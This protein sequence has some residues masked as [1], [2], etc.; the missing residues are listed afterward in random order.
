MCRC[1]RVRK[2]SKEE[3]MKMFH[4]SSSRSHTSTLKHGLFDLVTVPL[5]PPHTSLSSLVSHLVA[6]AAGTRL[7]CAVAGGELSE[8]RGQYTTWAEL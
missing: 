1:S 8:G 2:N 4:K 7:V 3:K 6:M 5:Y